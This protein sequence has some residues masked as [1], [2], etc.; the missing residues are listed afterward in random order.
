MKYYCPYCGIRIKKN[1]KICNRCDYHFRR[2]MDRCKEENLESTDRSVSYDI[3]S[4]KKNN[5]IS[6]TNY[7]GVVIVLVVLL[8]VLCAFFS[9]MFVAMRHHI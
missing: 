4:K 7:I 6:D 9:G 3:S 1:Q 2:P 8:I 5:R